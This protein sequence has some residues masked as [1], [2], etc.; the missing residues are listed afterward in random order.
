MAFSEKQRQVIYLAE[1][2]FCVYNPDLPSGHPLGRAIVPTPRRIHFPSSVF[3]L[4]SLLT[5]MAFSQMDVVA[6]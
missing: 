3:P 6:S 5:I 1:P 2:L 4:R